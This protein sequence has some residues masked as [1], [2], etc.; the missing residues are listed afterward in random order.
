MFIEGF[1]LALTISSEPKVEPVTLARYTMK[2]GTSSDKPERTTPKVA[3][4]SA[5]ISTIHQLI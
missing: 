3:V 2:L 4:N 1:F 5:P